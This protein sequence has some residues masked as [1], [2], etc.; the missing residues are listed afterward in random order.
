MEE[1]LIIGSVTAPFG[2]RGE[3][4]VFPHTD[5][6]SRFKKLKE[7]FLDTGKEKLSLHPESVKYSKQFV[8]IKFREFSNPNEV[9]CLRGKN[10]LVDRAHAVKLQKDEYFITDLIGLD[11]VREDGSRLGV[12]KDVMQTGANDVYIVLKE[13][14]TEILL[15]AIKECI[16]DVDMEKR[17]MK[18]F[19]MPGL[20]S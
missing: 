17:V 7:V 3:V 10:L 5:D 12:L 9:E 6:V 11:V 8:I 14:Q 15:P 19:V 20:E 4:K 13:D 18:V 16:L 1:Y 2:V